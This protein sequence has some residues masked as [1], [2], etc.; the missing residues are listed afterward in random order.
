RQRGVGLPRGVV[1][2]VTGDPPLIPEFMKRFPAPVS[3]FS[4]E[5][6]PPDPGASEDAPTRHIIR[7]T[8]SCPV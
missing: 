3:L 8:A 2:R 7:V 1:R 5:R 4:L 6:A